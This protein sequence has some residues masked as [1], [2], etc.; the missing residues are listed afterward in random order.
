MNT[1]DS[2]LCRYASYQQCCVYCWRPI[3]L[4]L[5]LTYLLSLFT[6]LLSFS[7]IIVIVLYYMMFSSVYLI[8]INTYHNIFITTTCLLF[9]HHHTIVIHH[10]HALC[11]HAHHS[12]IHIIIYTHPWVGRGKPFIAETNATTLVCIG[13]PGV[14]PCQH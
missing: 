9:H 3:T 2:G 13:V 6:L 10:H 14:A 7:Q 1:I 5:H 11:V 4:L 8:I 12:F